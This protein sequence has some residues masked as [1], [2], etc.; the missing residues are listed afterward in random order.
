LEKVVG[1]EVEQ[2]DEEEEEDVGGWRGGV[3][4]EEE[5]HFSFF[6]FFF[7]FFFFSR[8]ILAYKTKTTVQMDWVWNEC[9]GDAL[10]FFV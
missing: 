7:F 8:V 10:S 9:R 4:G 1:P 3:E 6:S 5:W 2:V